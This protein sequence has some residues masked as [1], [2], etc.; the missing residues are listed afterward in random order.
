MI[1]KKDIIGCEKF[2]GLR[3]S[4]YYVFFILL[5]ISIK[6]LVIVLILILL[7]WFLVKV[8]IF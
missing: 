7:K 4:I 5:Y 1:G 2:E 8:K 3:V 6:F